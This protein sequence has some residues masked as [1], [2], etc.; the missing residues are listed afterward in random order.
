M[1]NGAVQVSTRLDETSSHWG[2]RPAERRSISNFFR[3]A[4]SFKSSIPEAR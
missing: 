1:V 4:S 3:P 2:P